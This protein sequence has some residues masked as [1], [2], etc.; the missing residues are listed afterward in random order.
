MLNPCGK[1]NIGCK[2]MIILKLDKKDCEGA[3]CGKCAYVCPN[4]VFTIEKDE[5]IITS[6]NY[7]KFCKECLE[8]CPTAAIN[9]KTTKSSICGY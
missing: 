3:T 8:V 5:I 1:L 4:N 9:I 6:P 7:C 2:T